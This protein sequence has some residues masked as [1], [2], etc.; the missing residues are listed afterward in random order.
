MNTLIGKRIVCK[1]ISSEDNYGLD[2]LTDHEEVVS[3]DRVGNE[4]I[5][6]DT[7]AIGFIE[8]VYIDNY[9]DENGNTKRVLFGNVV[10]WNDDKY[11]NIVG[12]LQ[13][14]IN[15][16]IKIHM[17]VEYLYC[18]YNVID[19]I[20]YLQ[21]PIL[22]VAHT[23]LNSEQRNEYA[24]ILPAYDCATLISLNERK[25]WN[26]TINQLTKKNNNKQNSK[27][28]NNSG[29][30]IKNNQVEGDKM[31]EDIKKN[32]IEKTNDNKEAPAIEEQIKEK[33]NESIE[34]NEKI[35]SLEKQ[36][37]TKNEEIIKANEKIV[38]LERQLNEKEESIKSLN[39]KINSTNTEK[40]EIETKFNDVTDKLTSLNT[41]VEEMKPI[42]EKYNKEQFEKELNEMK[43]TYEKKFKSVNA[44]EKFK[45][46]EV[47]EL[48][49]KS[50]NKNNEGQKAI[51]S[52]NKM[53]VD[54]IS[55][56]EKEDIQ[57]EEK[58]SLNSVEKGT[59]NKNLR[60]DISKIENFY[61]ISLNE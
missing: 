53:V 58:L 51:T 33:P 23:L 40:T 50:L 36:L 37:D 26:K 43:S 10:I 31:A 32:E 21:T 20:E 56:D 45:S 46:D 5:T 49:K 14:W 55:F 39:E 17:S 12:L 24:E 61:G 25:K 35:K 6:T 4:V 41:K 57:T 52:L 22:Y 42:V 48:I 60:E 13:E 16:G 38:D 9:T 44:I 47:Q 54:A 8:N 15:R 28:E 1:Y 2:A 27:S 19:G 59:E 18:N 34:V 30:N 11:A 29:L 7:I 3:K